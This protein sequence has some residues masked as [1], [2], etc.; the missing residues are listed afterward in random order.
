MNLKV[1]ALV[2][3]AVVT[4][5]ASACG[6]GGATASP[7]AVGSPAGSSAGGA[8]SEPSAAPSI[9]TTPVTIKVWDYYGDSTPIKPALAGFAKEFPW[10]TVDYQALDWD[11]MNE[12]FTAG[13]GAGEVPDMATLDMTWLPTLAANGALDDLTAAVGR[14]AQR[15]ADRGPVHARA[16]STR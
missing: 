14:P 16:P 7:A 15:Q 6:S 8:S 12:K 5:V 3:L 2:G 13:I 4:I 10:I 1:R 9:D 11:S